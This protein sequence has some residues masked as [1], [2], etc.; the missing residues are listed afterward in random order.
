MHVVQARATP[1][2][3]LAEG[4]SSSAAYAKGLWVRL[5]GGGRRGGFHSN[6]Q[7]LPSD[8]PA[9]VSSRA[10]RTA[11]IAQLSRE[12][13]ALEQKLQEASKVLDA[14]HYHLPSLLQL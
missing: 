7:G 6:A 14:L 10:S 4:L 5:N 12:I 8:L 3:A 13:D 11:S 1:V 2:T 9:P